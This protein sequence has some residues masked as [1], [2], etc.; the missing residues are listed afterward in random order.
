VSVSFDAPTVDVLVC[1][2][3]FAAG[4]VKAWIQGVDMADIRP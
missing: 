4:F 2:A 1:M 3:L